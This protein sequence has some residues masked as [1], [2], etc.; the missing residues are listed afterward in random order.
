[1]NIVERVAQSL[2]RRQHARVTAAWGPG[3]HWRRTSPGFQMRLDR[4]DFDDLAFHFGGFDDAFVRDASALVHAGERA[5]DIGAQ[6]GFF[7]MLLARAVGSQGAVLAI[8]ADPAALELLAEHVAHN[9]FKQVRIADCAVGERDGDEITF[10]LSQQIGWSSR[11]PNPH[12]SPLVQR[13][14]TLKT[15][16]VDSLVAERMSEISAPVSL[17]KIDVEGSEL[18]VVRGMPELL[19]THTPTLWMEINRPSL[20]AAGTSPAEVEALLA[21][22]GYRFYLPDYEP[23]LFGGARVWYTPYAHLDDVPRPEF[24]IVCVA[25]RYAGRWKF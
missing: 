7:A 24:D 17:V 10:H 18:R 4:A 25:P 12:Q 15:R 8:E 2:R 19:R 9:D 23:T 1:V 14:L 6:K 5:V 22:F 16:T 3:R 13:A 21:P 11:F 20:A